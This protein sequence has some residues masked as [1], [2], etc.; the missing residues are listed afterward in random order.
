MRSLLKLVLKESASNRFY[1]RHGFLFV[2]SRELTVIMF[3][4]AFRWLAG[5]LA[6]LAASWM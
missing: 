6:G 4:R 3:V 2:E 5:W 1:T